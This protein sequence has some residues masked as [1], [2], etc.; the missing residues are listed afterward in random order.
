[1]VKDGGEIMSLEEMAMASAVLQAACGGHSYAGSIGMFR[2][3]GMTPKQYG[4]MLSHSRKNR[5]YR[6]RRKKRK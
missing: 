6:G 1:M 5:K 3:P 2:N 4:I